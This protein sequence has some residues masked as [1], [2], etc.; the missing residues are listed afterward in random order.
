MLMD[1]NSFRS[2]SDNFAHDLFVQ[3]IQ[4]LCLYVYIL[5]GLGLLQALVESLNLSL[6]QDFSQSVKGRVTGHQFEVIQK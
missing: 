1:L 6:L 5:I 3:E 2:A 4:A